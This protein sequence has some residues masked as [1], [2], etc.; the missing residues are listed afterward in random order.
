MKILIVD[1]EY[2]KVQ[3]ISSVINQADIVGIDI[4]QDTTAQAARKRL[5]D[6]YFDMLIID[7][8]LP[9]AVGGK[10][11]DNGGISFFD[12]IKLD[13]KVKLPT[14]VLFITGKE[15]L[16]DL[17]NTAVIERGGVLC[18][19]R[20]DSDQWKNVLKGR[21]RY[22]FQRLV[23]N[24]QQ[25]DVVIVTALINPELDAVLKLPYEWKSKRFHGDPLTYYFGS[26][27]R[28][29][30]NISVVTVSPNRK[31]M[32]S[33]AVVASKLALM[34]R[35]KYL[36]MLGIC[37]GIP[38]KSNLGDVIVADPTWDWGSGKRGTDTNG[39][40]VFQAAPY[41]RSLNNGISQ[42]ASCMANDSEVLKAIKG[43]WTEAVPE[44][45]LKIHVG[46]MAS[47]ASVIADDDATRSIIIQHRELLAIE[48]EAYAVMAAAEFADD[49]KPTAIIIKSVCDYADAEKND[50]WQKYASYTSAAFANQLFFNPNM[51][52]TR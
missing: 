49:P 45:S 1:D 33:S 46:P 51:R 42:L 37:A 17:A 23:S 3:E 30:G 52:F 50:A 34:F 25:V 38:G 13:A 5:Q 7:L 27:S 35:P 39:S 9:D 19:Y 40:S 6:M 48:M 26:I 31:G 28:S 24:T 36:V 21:V 20:S 8:H 32:P 18:Q 22:T 41:Q 4:V 14:D 16:I 47:G 44:G 43:E 11:D 29:D 10:P 12:M 15:D 2:S